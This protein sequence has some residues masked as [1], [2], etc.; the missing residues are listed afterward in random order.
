[1]NACI[2]DYRKGDCLQHG[3]ANVFNYLVEAK[4]S[5]EKLEAFGPKGTVKLID[6]GMSMTGPMGRDVGLAL[7]Y[8]IGCMIGHA[9]CGQ[10]DAN[11]T[12]EEFVNTLINKYCGNMVQAG[13]TPKEMATLVRQIVG[14][15]GWFQYLFFYILN[16]FE[17]P[18]E[19][20]AGHTR[21]R[22]ALG[23]L[24][25][26]LL[27]LSYDT[28]TVPETTVAGDICKMFNALWKEEVKRAQEA[29]VA[30]K[31]KK[32]PRKSSIFREPG[33]RQSSSNMMYLASDEIRRSSATARSSF[34]ARGTTTSSATESSVD[35][36]YMGRESVGR[37]SIKSLIQTDIEGSIRRSL[38]RL[39]VPENLVLEAISA[40]E[41]DD[42]EW[43][44]V[45]EEV[46]GMNAAA[47]QFPT[48]SMTKKDTASKRDVWSKDS[49]FNRSKRETTT[50]DGCGCNIL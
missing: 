15:C 27:R 39:S 42:D 41:F 29:F 13:K 48:A 32:Q 19:S 4:P 10:S 49:V 50:T 36:S 40:D 31:F 26:E 37:E 45:T 34:A 30:G 28:K 16:V 1:M 14:W 22:D 2:K 33:R 18:G 35:I 9:L 24:G 7:C 21:L 12:I 47:D 3:D 25:L 8:P 23:I 20:E 5:I 44:S 43:E 17:F 11:E 46:T 38:G 6:W